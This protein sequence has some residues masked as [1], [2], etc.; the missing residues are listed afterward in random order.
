MRKQH[1][2]ELEW[3]NIKLHVRRALFR[4]DCDELVPEFWGELISLTE[5]VDR[6]T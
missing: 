1:F 2:E 5:H 4:A 3:N 6:M